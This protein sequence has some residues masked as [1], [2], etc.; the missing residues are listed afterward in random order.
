MPDVDVASTNF[1]QISYSKGNAVLRQLV[2]WLGDEA[3]LAGVNAHL[4]A[5]RFANATLEDLVSALDAAS[6]LDV[7]AWSA[8]WLRESGHDTLRVVRDADGVPSLVRDGVR[9][10]RLLVTAYDDGLAEVG[11]RWVSLDAEPVAFPEWA[12]LAVVPNTHGDTFARSELDE[13]SWAAVVSS[14]GALEDDLARAVLWGVAVDAGRLADVLA[15]H[16]PAERHPDLVAGRGALVAGALP[17]PGRPRHRVPRGPGRGRRPRRLHPRAG[18]LLLGR[19]GA[20]ALAGRRPH[21]PRRRARPG[22]ALDPG[23]PPGP[24]RRARRG[25]RPVPRRRHRRGRPRRPLRPGRAP[26]GRGQGGGLGVV[27]DPAV[28]NRRFGALAEGLWSPEHPELC[29]PYVEAYLEAGPGLA[30]RGPSFAQSV[31][32]AFP[33]LPLTVEQLDLVRAALEGEVPTVLRRAW[34]DELDDRG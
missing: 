17:A 2:A 33:A 25:R 12:G 6:P 10:H 8:L 11:A 4:T 1:D 22:P 21:R 9:P 27:L 19:R 7:R 26:D 29:A 34:E 15:L 23:A 32:R 18:R 30:A 5:H 24:P 16:L 13:T 31:G 20:R 28:S 3:F 14:L